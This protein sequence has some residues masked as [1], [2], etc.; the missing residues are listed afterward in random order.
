MLV[1]SGRSV[2]IVG[3]NGGGNG[4][5]EFWVVV[6]YGRRQLRLFDYGRRQLRLFDYD[7]STTIV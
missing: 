3:G 2:S 5:G 7:C 4:G 1:R 6:D